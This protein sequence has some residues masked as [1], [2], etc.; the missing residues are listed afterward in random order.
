[1]L[2]NNEIVALKKR[3]KAGDVWWNDGDGLCKLVCSVNLE[4][5]EFPSE[6]D[7]VEPAAILAGGVAV[8]LLNVELSSFVTITPCIEKPSEK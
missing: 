5:V 4:W 2:T 1:M 7:S 3:V 6:P 8:A